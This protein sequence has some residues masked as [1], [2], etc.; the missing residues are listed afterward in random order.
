MTGV[1]KFGECG[2]GNAEKFDPVGVGVLEEG[3][4]G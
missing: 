4:E 1:G 2:A 3:A